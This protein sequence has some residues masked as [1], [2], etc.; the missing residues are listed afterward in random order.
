MESERGYNIGP[1]SKLRESCGNN[2]K[3]EGNCPK[4]LN[5]K[6]YNNFN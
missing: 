2:Y 1:S 3:D 4:T 5:D 6:N